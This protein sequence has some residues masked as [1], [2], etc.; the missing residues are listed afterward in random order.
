MKQNKESCLPFSF[1]AGGVKIKVYMAGGSLLLKDRQD[2]PTSP[3]NLGGIH[4]HFAY[5]AFFA[6]SHPLSLVTAQGAEAYRQR[7]VLLPPKLLHYS[8]SPGEGN[9]CLL[10][11]FQEQSDAAERLHTVLHSGIC[12]LDLEAEDA[13]CIQNAAE[14]L[15]R[16]Y[17]EEAKLLIRLIFLRILRRLLPDSREAPAP[18]NSGHMNAIETFINNNLTG[19]LTLENVSRHVHLSSRQVSRIIRQEWDCTLVQLVTEKRLA[20]AEMLLKGTKL[21]VSDIAA[22]IFCSNPNYFYSLFRRRYGITPL[23]YRKSVHKGA[24]P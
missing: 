7:I 8:F 15:N 17:G 22:S 1:S 14:A 2:F 6:V 21:P 24:E 10:F 11:T 20:R 18:Q 9:Y 19:N 13:F 23:Q 4:S 3:E 12:A 5:E 16:G